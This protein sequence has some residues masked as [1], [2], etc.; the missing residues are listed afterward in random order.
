MTATIERIP[1]ARAET[2]ATEL[3]IGLRRYCERIEI[4]GSIRRRRP[5]VH[6]IELVCIPRREPLLVD[7]F[8]QVVGYR[9]QLHEFVEQAVAAGR[10]EHRLDKNGRPAFG[11]K[12]K[13]LQFKGIGLDLF[14]VIEPAQ[15]GMIFVIRT[16]SADFTHRL[17]TQ[18]R[19]G[20]L[21]PNYW[22]VRDGALWN[23][24]GELITTPEEADVFTALGMDWIAPEVRS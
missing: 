5:D 24:R 23:E 8:G 2:L 15:F 13:R 16:G 6:D 21:L 11:E 19:F 18:Q 4:A 1:L 22:S 10:L 12:Y 3:M 14:S 17:V 20:G 7:F 9:D